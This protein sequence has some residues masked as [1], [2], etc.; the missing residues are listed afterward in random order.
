MKSLLRKLTGA[1]WESL[2][3]TETQPWLSPLQNLLPETPRE[4]LGRIVSLRGK[5]F[6][7]EDENAACLFEGMVIEVMEGL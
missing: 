7:E 4:E 1:V 5:T 3:K 6:D 2:P